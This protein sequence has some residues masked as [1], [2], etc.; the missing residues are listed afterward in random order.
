MEGGNTD[1]GAVQSRSPEPTVA[2]I[3]S[4]SVKTM[5]SGGPR[6]HDAGKKIKGR[7]RQIAGDAEGFPIAVHVHTVDFQDRDGAT[8]VILD[9]LEGAPTVAKLFADGRYQGPKLRGVLKD[10]AVADMIKI[11][12]KPSPSFTG[13]G[14]LREV[15]P[16]WADTAAWQ[17]TSNGRLKSPL[18]GRNWPLV[19]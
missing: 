3:D 4:Q 17:K 18:L 6:G 11:A 15:L 19:A 14:L 1:R 12:G 16:G 9:M 5:E 13:D 8:E 10:R 7:K 2:V